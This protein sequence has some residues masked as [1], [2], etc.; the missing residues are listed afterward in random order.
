MK[1]LS[2]PDAHVILLSVAA[3]LLAGV[4]ASPLPLGLSTDTNTAAVARALGPGSLQARAP[5][6]A[7]R[8]SEHI[9]FSYDY[10][11]DTHA[12]DQAS[13]VFDRLTLDTVTSGRSLP[14]N[15]GPSLTSRSSG[16]DSLMVRGLNHQM[17]LRT[18]YDEMPRLTFSKEKRSP[19]PSLQALGNPIQTFF[20]N[21]LAKEK[22]Q[23]K[24]PTLGIRMLRLDL[25]FALTEEK[26][27]KD[28]DVAILEQ[29]ME[30]DHQEFLKFVEDKQDG[31]LAKVCLS[32]LMYYKAVLANKDHVAFE[33][34]LPE[35]HYN[36]FLRRNI[37]NLKS[38][39]TLGERIT[40][41]GLK[42]NSIRQEGF[43]PVD[44]K[45]FEGDLSL[46]LLQS[47][48]EGQEAKGGEARA[49]YYLALFQL[50]EDVN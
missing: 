11:R 18:K 23:D 19:R 33:V 43:Y 38:S 37:R 14:E 2:L 31:Q 50:R 32:R 13:H 36:D 17:I 8:D 47:Q 9:N 45:S 7:S 27:F 28:P 15:T 20:E 40:M 41:L 22:Y 29:Q 39:D 4:G 35:N 21:E 44:I 34:P 26:D 46:Y 24:N 5:Q 3:S 48:G 1:L 42:Y 6:A 10:V 16:S 25:L 12:T 49:K 30:K